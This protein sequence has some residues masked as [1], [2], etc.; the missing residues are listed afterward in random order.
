MQ[1]IAVVILNWNGKPFL[2]QFLPS[3][4]SHTPSWAEIVVADNA[5]SDDSV[6]FMQSHY[7]QVRL[8]LNDGNFGFAK[9][10]NQALQQVDAEYYCLLNSDIEVA[11]QWIEPVIDY[12][13][14]HLQVAVCQPKLLSFAQKSHFEYA[15]AA[16]GFI[17]KYGYPFCQGRL[18]DCVEKDE[19]KYD[20]AKEIFWATGACM[21]IRSKVYHELGGL[22]DDFFAHMEEIDLCWRAKNAGYKVMYIPNSTVYHVGGGTLPKNSSHKTYL[23]FRNNLILLYKNLPK[24]RIL[25]VFSMR[26]VLDLVASIRFLFDSGWSDFAAVF[27]A[28]F[29]FYGSLQK[30]RKKRTRT[31]HRNVSQTYRKSI[32]YDYYMRKKKLFSD[33]NPND[34]S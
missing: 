18:F 28:Y 29:S 20:E 34:F 8:I 9:G 2:E 24:R 26:L 22:D 7:P 19:G 21:F 16:G 27:K 17:D 10:Y 31:P 15:G 4:V 33:L 6:A 12:L 3:L 1:K 25:R 13:D 30:N 11:S 23:N 5:S 32:V 14:T